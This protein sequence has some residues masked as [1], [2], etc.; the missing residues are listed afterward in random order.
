MRVNVGGNKS[1]DIP[2]H[3]LKK[4]SPTHEGVL[5]IK[6][7][8]SARHNQHN[9]DKK[10]ILSS[11][12]VFDLLLEIGRGILMRRNV[13]LTLP[14]AAGWQFYA[15]H[16]FGGRFGFSWSKATRIACIHFLKKEQERHVIESFKSYFLKLRWRYTRWR[17]FILTRAGGCPSRLLQR[18]PFEQHAAGCVSP[19]MCRWGFRD[20]FHK[21][22]C[23]QKY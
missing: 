13:F 5:E 6:P 16:S 12:S 19:F 20:W 1:V 8:P 14:L 17:S 21:C 10:I 18:F 7:R 9:S 2:P 4:K 11:T 23:V 3:A 22:D 15:R